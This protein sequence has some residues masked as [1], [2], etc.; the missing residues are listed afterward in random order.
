M[1]KPTRAMAA[2]GGSKSST[3]PEITRAEWAFAEA[4][5]EAEMRKQGAIA[6]AMQIKDVAAHTAAIRAAEK[7]YHLALAQAAAATKLIDPAPY[8]NAANG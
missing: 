3:P 1:T 2:S 5:A 7:Q 4:K 8:L 6:A